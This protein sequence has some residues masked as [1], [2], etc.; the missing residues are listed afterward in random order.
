[1]TF[2]GL[3][4]NPDM[5]ASRYRD[6]IATKRLPTGMVLDLKEEAADMGIPL[7]L[8][9]Q[10]MRILTTM[11]LVS[12]PSPDSVKIREMTTQTLQDLEFSLTRRRL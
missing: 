4:D 2:L 11:G 9:K 8:I 7:S 5:L 6:A 3:V 10:A 1:M 12:W